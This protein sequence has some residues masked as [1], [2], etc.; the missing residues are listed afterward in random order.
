MMDIWEK[1]FTILGIVLVLGAYF[2]LQ[3]KGISPGG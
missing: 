2:F 3:K 1:V